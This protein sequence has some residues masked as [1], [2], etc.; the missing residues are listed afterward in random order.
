MSISA[1]MTECSELRT[2]NP[3]AMGSSSALLPLSEPPTLTF[4]GVRHAFLSH[5]EEDCV[6]NQ[7]KSAREASTGYISSATLV[8]SQPVRYNLTGLTGGAK[9]IPTIK[10]GISTFTFCPMDPRS[11]PFSIESPLISEHGVYCENRA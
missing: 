9:C 11:E 3:E 8:N 7:R 1:E 10:N 2:R 6:T 4:L 5:V